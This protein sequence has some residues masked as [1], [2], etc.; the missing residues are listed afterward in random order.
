GARRGEDAEHP[1]RTVALAQRHRADLDPHRVAVGGDVTGRLIT[2]VPDPGEVPGAM[3][4]FGRRASGADTEDFS[5]DLIGADG[6]EVR[7]EI[8]SVPLRE[9]H[10]AIG[11]F[12]V[13]TSPPEGAPR[14]PK[15]DS[16]LTPRQ[17]EVLRLLGE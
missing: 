15:V 2:S 13:F 12:G 6:D 10:R 4:A 8:G 14:A 1:D 7:V 3:D 9:G 16:R 17:R 5:I 11:M